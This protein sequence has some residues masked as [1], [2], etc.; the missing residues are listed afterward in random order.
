MRWRR[1]IVLSAKFNPNP[2]PNT[3]TKGAG[4]RKEVSAGAAGF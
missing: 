3:G 4:A 2:E 1:Y